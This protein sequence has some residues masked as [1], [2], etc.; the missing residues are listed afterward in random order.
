MSPELSPRAFS[1]TLRPDHRPQVTDLRVELEERYGDGQLEPFRQLLCVS[2]H[3]TAGFMDPPLR[4][5]LSAESSRL[6]TF[7]EALSEIFPPDAGYHHDRLELRAELSEEQRRREPLNADAH[8]SFIGGG[9]SNCVVY[10]GSSAQPLWFVDFDGA[11]RDSSDR[12]VRRT[13]SAVVVGFQEEEVVQRVE[14]EVA[15]AADRQAVRLRNGSGC[16]TDKLAAEVRRLGIEYGRID[17]KLA[18]EERGSG[19]TVNEFEALLMERDLTEVLDEPLRYA[20]AGSDLQKAMGALGVSP[21]RRDRM[22]DR[23]LEGTPAR[24]L[25]VRRDVSV[26]ILPGERG[27]EIIRGTYQSPILVQWEPSASGTRRVTAEIIRLS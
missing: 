13:R 18:P 2:Y 4:R 15:T 14:L 6:D 9:F 7:L 17:L 8:L 24:I 23:A 1:L 10:E 11:Y 25:R 27:G 3:T 19:I 22:L 12:P 26:A 16:I 21:D 20:E 5:R